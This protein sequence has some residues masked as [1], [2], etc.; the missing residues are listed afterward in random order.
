MPTHRRDPRRFHQ[1][2]TILEGSATLLYNTCILNTEIPARQMYLCNI[3]L[4]KFAENRVTR[5]NNMRK[6][7]WKIWIARM[8]ITT[9]GTKRC[10]SL[11]KPRNSLPVPS[12]Q[13]MSAS[14]SDASKT[15][16][17]PVKTRE[18]QR[19]EKEQNRPLQGSVD[20]A[21]EDWNADKTKEENVQARTLVSSRICS[22]RQ[23]L[24]EDVFYRPRKLRT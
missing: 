14:R 3:A 19:G 22:K 12:R 24:C 21:L 2:D 10:S 7:F 8:S 15:A 6:K 11:P 20:D 16:E 13:I 4:T 1:Y 5:S 18:A 9:Y 17:R 23:N